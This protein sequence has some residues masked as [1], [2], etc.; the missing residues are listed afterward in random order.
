LFRTASQELYADVW[1][2]ETFER[3][4]SVIHYKKSKIIKKFKKSYDDFFCIKKGQH[5]I[6]GSL[7]LE[8]TYPKNHRIILS[9]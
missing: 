2:Y 3:G 5:K 1:E 4:M 9:H 6:L 7:L 8:C